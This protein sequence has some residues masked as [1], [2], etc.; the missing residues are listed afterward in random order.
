MKGSWK[1]RLMDPIQEA[2]DEGYEKNVAQ[3]RLKWYDHWMKVCG[4]ETWEEIDWTN[5]IVSLEWKLCDSKIQAKLMSGQR[6][7]VLAGFTEEER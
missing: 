1:K 3:A 6:E 4:V 5:P 7:I 2:F